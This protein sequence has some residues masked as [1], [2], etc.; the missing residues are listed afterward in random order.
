MPKASERRAAI[1]TP[2]QSMKPMLSLPALMQMIVSNFGTLLLIVAAF[3]IGMLSTEVRYLKKGVGTAGTGTQQ[4]VQQAPQPPAGVTLSMDQ[5]KGLFTKGSIMFGDPN[6]KLLIV[7]VSDPSCPFCHVAAGK[8]PELSK[9][10]GAQFTGKADGGS[11]VPPV[12]EMKKLV[13]S[14]KAAFLWIYSPGHGQGEMGTKALYCAFEKGKFWQVHDLLMSNAGYDLLNNKVKNDK[15][16][17]DVLAEFLKPAMNPSD[18]KSCIAS[19]K[20]DAKL[21]EDTQIAQKIGY[22][23]TPYFVLNTKTFSG[24]YSFADMQSTVDQALK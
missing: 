10:M 7:E 24:A 11:Y 18:L 15:A 5:V 6:K 13:D 16:Q 4:A 9:Q 2:A 17:V 22:Q 21:A 3:L 19:G 14:G 20:Y 1:S 23:G 8:N 12:P